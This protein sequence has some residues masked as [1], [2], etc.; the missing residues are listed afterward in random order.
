MSAIE[1]L[2]KT[3]LALPLEQRIVLAES[4][5]DSLPRTVQIW[6]DAEELA[7]VE[8][9]ER[10]IESGEV[11]PLSEAEFWQRVEARRKQ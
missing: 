7:E 9:R 3:V 11:R 5:L 2:E 8:R 1:E 4:L 6:S 10:E